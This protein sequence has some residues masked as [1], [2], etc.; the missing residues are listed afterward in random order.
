MK[1]KKLI[2]KLQELDPEGEMDCCVGNTDIFTI[3]IEPSYYDGCKQILIRDED[4]PYY[5][6]IGAK[7]T[8][9]G[10]KLC[11]DFLSVKDALWENSELPIEYDD[12]TER[13]YKENYD[14]IREEVREF[15]K[16][17]ENDRH[18]NI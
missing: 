15:E 4:N 10:Y 7:I 2:E 9:K 8:S 11:I 18:K 16:E 17:L 5:N 1:T 6:V 13:Y 14:K 3:G 12:Y